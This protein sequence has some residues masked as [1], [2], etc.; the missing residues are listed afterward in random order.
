[1]TTPLNNSVVKAFQLL[2]AFK[3]AP[4]GLSLTEA[5]E[6]V[7]LAVPTAHRFLRTL[8]STGALDQTATGRY[9]VGSALLQLAQ[10]GPDTET[11][12]AILDHHVCQLA[13]TLRETVHVAVLDRD[14]VHY[15]AKAETQ[16]SLKMVTKVGTALEAYCTGV[17]KL[18]L[19]HQSADYVAR[20]L[21]NGDL[22]ALTPNTITNK[23]VMFRELQAI[24]E[25]G[26]A[27]DDEEFETGLR[28]VAAPITLNGTV[29]GALSCSAPSSRMGDEFLPTFLAATRR[30]AQ[31]IASEYEK[32]GLRRLN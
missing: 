14:M 20:Y 28:C 24:R 30:R 3:Q 17:G 15:V 25:Q 6:R 13:A 23:D 5:A 7:S 31:M 26:Y 21:G 16:R 8:L 9:V 22:V 27:L 1:M 10:T 11:P 29:V 19:A 18:L 4:H 2:A 32:R 12:A